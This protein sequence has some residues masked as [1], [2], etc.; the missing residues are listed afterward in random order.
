M[1]FSM[2][3]KNKT[4]FRSSMS[5]SMLQSILIAKSQISGNCFSKIYD[6]NFLKKAKSATKAGLNQVFE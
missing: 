5:I 1:V 2:V 3:R 4:D 6:E